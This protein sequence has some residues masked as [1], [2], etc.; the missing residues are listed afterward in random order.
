MEILPLEFVSLPIVV[1]DYDKLQQSESGGNTPSK[2]IQSTSAR[3]A[4]AS[5]AQE[6]D[7]VF[8]DEITDAAEDVWKRLSTAMKTKV[9]E[10]CIEVLR[11]TDD[12]NS[13]EKPHDDFEYDDDARF[14][15]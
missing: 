10:A 4:S 13:S 12:T 1:T 6:D 2:E 7:K 5:E 11:R 15:D 14:L 9:R 8:I 3:P